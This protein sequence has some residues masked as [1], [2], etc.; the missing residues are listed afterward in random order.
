MP[1]EQ[2]YKLLDRYH[3]AVRSYSQSV[4]DLGDPDFIAA[5]QNAEAALKRCNAARAIL[6]DHDRVHGCTTGEWEEEELVLGDQ[7]QSGG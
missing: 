6:L 1:C 4:A 5:W 2:W 7:G 3:R